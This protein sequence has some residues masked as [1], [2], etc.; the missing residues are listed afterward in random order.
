MSSITKRKGFFLS[1]D[2]EI[3]QLR[4]ENWELNNR[5][6]A[7]EAKII[8]LKYL[9]QSMRKRRSGDLPME[10]QYECIKQLNEEFMKR[11][12]SLEQTI[13]ELEMDKFL[14]IT[15]GKRET[16]KEVIEERNE[17]SDSLSDG[18]HME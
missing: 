5:I 15:N 4:K 14:L 1:K 17:E 8:K 12:R 11:I 10:S 13:R 9:E 7:A 16:S 2:L 3:R 18:L 6:R